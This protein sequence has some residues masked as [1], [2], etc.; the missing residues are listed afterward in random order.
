MVQTAGGI[1]CF[2]SSDRCIIRCL[3]AYTGFGNRFCKKGLVGPSHEK[4]NSMHLYRTLQIQCAIYIDTY[5]KSPLLSP[6]TIHVSQMA[7]HVPYKQ[8]IE[9]MKMTE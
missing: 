8:L 7:C 5:C 6:R 1:R 2:T 9:N 3:C 4:E